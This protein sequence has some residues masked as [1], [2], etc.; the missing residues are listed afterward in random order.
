MIR[1]THPR[2]TNYKGRSCDY[3]INI[4]DFI[5]R[6]M[7]IQAPGLIF[8]VGLIVVATIFLVFITSTK[9]ILPSKYFQTECIILSNSKE[10]TLVSI[11]GLYGKCNYYDKYPISLFYPISS[12]KYESHAVIN[13]NVWLDCPKSMTSKKRI[14]AIHEK[15]TLYF[16]SVRFSFFAFTSTLITVSM[17]CIIYQRIKFI[18]LMHKQHRNQR[19]DSD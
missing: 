6:P 9:L 2:I 14:I 4:N 19:T 11:D 8:P 10:G 7:K 3:I 16:R 17:S 15:D 18:L 5:S 1:S 12:E 13:C